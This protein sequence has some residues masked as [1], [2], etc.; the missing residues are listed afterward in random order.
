MSIENLKY[1]L[2]KYKAR[3]KYLQRLEAINQNEIDELSKK[4]FILQ[5]MLIEEK[6][7]VKNDKSKN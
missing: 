1:L 4:I 7:V 3:R 6:K 5:K 2:Y